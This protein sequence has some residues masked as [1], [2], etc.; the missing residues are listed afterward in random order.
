MQ[1]HAYSSDMTAL[2]HTRPISVY[3]ALSYIY[4]SSSARARL[5]GSSEDTYIYIVAQRT[6]I[7][8]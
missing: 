5:H 4:E 3:E 2:W 6:H 1:E 7:Y 8:T